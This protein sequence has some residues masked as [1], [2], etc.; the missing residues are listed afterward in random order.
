M[1]NSVLYLQSRFIAFHYL[2]MKQQQL[3]RCNR[4]IDDIVELVRGKLDGGARITLGALI[5]IDVHG[6]ELQYFCISVSLSNTVHSGV[7]HSLP[8]RPASVFGTLP[9]I[10]CLVFAFFIALRAFPS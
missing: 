1:P 8:G 2:L 9:G 5:V 6:N 3:E 7:S 4:Q 10:R